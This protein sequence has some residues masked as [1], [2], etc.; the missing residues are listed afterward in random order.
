M[1]KKIGMECD[2]CCLVEVGNSGRMDYDS[3]QD[4]SILGIPG[5]LAK[6]I[7]ITHI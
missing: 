7:V 5:L 2:H 6:V 4:R 1:A 3:E